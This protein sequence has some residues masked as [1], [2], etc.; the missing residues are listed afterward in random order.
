[1]EMMDTVAKFAVNII[2]MCCDC[3]PRHLLY[4]SLTSQ[5][6]KQIPSSPL[7]MRL[8]GSGRLFWLDKGFMATENSYHA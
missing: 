8:R 4:Y 6:R 1:M 5:L 2:S 7:S 3:V